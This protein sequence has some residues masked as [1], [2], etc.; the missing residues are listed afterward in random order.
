LPKKLA[1]KIFPK[2]E[3]MYILKKSSIFEKRKLLSAGIVL[4]KR[5]AWAG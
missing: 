4:A 5:K 2:S 1:S 3:K